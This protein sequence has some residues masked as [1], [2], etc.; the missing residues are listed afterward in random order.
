MSEASG[1]QFCA[2]C[3]HTMLE[4]LTPEEVITLGGRRYRFRRHS[5]F[6]VCSHCFTLYRAVDLHRGRVV[7]VTDEDLLGQDEATLEGD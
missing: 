2:A 3:G 1:P 6:V 7:P 5:D 4:G